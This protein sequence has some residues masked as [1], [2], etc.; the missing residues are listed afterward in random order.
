M[1]VVASSSWSHSFLTHKFQCR[2]ID[3]ETDRRYSE[4]VT[5]GQGSELAKLSPE[6]IQDSGDHE[7]LNWIV[8]LGILGDRPAEIVDVRESHTQLAYS[9]A[10][11]WE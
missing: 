9:V 4:L 2:A 5:S 7:I 6:E 10:A 11:I 8:A 3:L 1:A